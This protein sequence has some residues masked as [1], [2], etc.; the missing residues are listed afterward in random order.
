MV[1]RHQQAGVDA[2]DITDPWLHNMIQRGMVGPAG[3]GLTLAEILKSGLVDARIKAN[4]AKIARGPRVPNAL[5]PPKD[6]LSGQNT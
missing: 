6:I 5:D 4:A 3:S 1:H 2:A